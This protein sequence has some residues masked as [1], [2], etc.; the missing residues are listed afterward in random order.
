MRT[1]LERK[2]LA[3]FSLLELLVS[4]AVISILGA[5]I[6]A[7]VGG[8]TNSAQST[9]TT[10]RLRNWFVFLQLYATENNG[11]ILPAY[12]VY[13]GHTGM[14]ATIGYRL[15]ENGYL[16]GPIEDEKTLGCDAQREQF[17]FKDAYS[18]GMNGRIGKPQSDGNFTP[19]GVQS[20]QEIIQP[21]KL[22][23]VMH[24]IWNGNAFNAAVYEAR[25]ANEVQPVFD[26]N[27]YILFADGNV[28]ARDPKTTPTERSSDEGRAFWLGK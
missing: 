27:V 15:I 19:L 16:A 20:F 5:I 25:Y 8:I 6:F 2:K 17:G 4:I 14:R 11:A 9:K 10:S 26:N 23:L 22:A 21:E 3:G 7:A 24:G 12:E 28:S 1:T 18:F 13:P